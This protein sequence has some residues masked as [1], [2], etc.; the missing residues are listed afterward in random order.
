[1]S[2]NFSSSLRD[3]AGSSCF[4]AD[5]GTKPRPERAIHHPG[6]IVNVLQHF[7]HQALRII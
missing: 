1:M 2:F 3:M 5:V 4:T 6:R 7:L